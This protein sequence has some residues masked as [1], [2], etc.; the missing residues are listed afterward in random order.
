MN[1]QRKEWE[2]NRRE[3]RKVGRNEKRMKGKRKEVEKDEYMM[4]SK[5][6]KRRAGRVRLSRKT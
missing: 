4:S 5:I 2:R 3:R 6:E 1:E